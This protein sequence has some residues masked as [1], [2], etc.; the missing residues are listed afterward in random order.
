MPMKMP[1]RQVGLIFAELGRLTGV[2]NNEVHAGM[3]IVIMLTTLLA[4]I[5]MKLYYQYFEPLVSGQR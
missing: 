1:A 5:W 3:V 2:F 4:P